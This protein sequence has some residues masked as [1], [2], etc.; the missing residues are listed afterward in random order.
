MRTGKKK[1]FIVMQSVMLFLA[2]TGLGGVCMWTGA[3]GD[4]KWSSESNWDAVPVAGDTIIL[5]AANCPEGAD[6]VPE[7]EVDVVDFRTGKLQIPEGAPSFRLKGNRLNLGGYVEPHAVSADLAYDAASFACAAAGAKV[8]IATESILSG[9][10]ASTSAMA[11][12]SRSPGCLRRT[13]R[14]APTST[15]RARRPAALP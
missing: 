5:A 4:G 10:A 6:G 3:A 8:E 7:I 13:P 11:R 15:S 9:G 1:W 12:T 2:E 14:T